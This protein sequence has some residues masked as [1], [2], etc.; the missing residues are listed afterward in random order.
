M[1]LKG[2]A[3]QASDNPGGRWPANLI[4]SHI[5]GPDGCQRVGTRLVK[6]DN[7]EPCLNLHNSGFYNVGE[8]ESEGVPRGAL[9]GDAL[10][11]D[12]KCLDGCPVRDL[13]EQSGCSTS[14]PWQDEIDP[15]LATNGAVYAGRQE[16]RTGFDD[17]SK[18]VGTMT[19]GRWPANLVLSHIGG[20][21]GCR[22]VGTHFEEFDIR[23]YLDPTSGNF[24]FWAEVE[25]TR[26]EVVVRKAGQVVEDWECVKGCPCLDL[27]E[28]SG[29]STSAL[30]QG[31]EGEYL[32]PSREGWR[33]RRATGG[34]ADTGGASRFFKQVTTV[35]DLYEY[36]RAMISPPIPFGVAVVLTAWPEDVETWARTS[37]TGFIIHGFTPTEAQTQVLYDLLTP[38]GY[39]CL[40]AP[41]EQPT[42]HTGAIRLED[43]GFEIRDALLWVRGPGRLH[44]IAKAARKE[45][46]A[47]C[48]KLPAKRGFEAVERKEGSAR[49]QNPRA[50]TGRTVD[51]VRNPHPCLHPEAVVMTDRGCRPIQ[52]I[53]V[54][55]WVLSA[56]GLFHR[57]EAVTRHPYTSEF[58]YRIGVKGTNLTTPASDN[59]PFLIWRPQRK[60]NYI[61]GGQVIWASA[62]QV[63]KG[64]YTMTPVMP[65]GSGMTAW[66]EDLDFWFV[67]GLWLAEGVSQVAG[68]GDNCYPSFSLHRKETYLV[69]RIKA[70]TTR[71]VSVYDQGENGV[72]VMAFDPELGAQF[73]ALGGSGSATKTIHPDVWLLTE[74]QRQALVEGYLAGDGGTVHNYRQAKSVSTDLATQMTFLAESLGYETN[75]FW[76]KADPGKIGDWHFKTTLP[77]YQMQFFSKDRLQTTRKAASPALVMHEGATYS[78]RYVQE[79]EKVPYQGDVVNLSVEGCP[80]FQT[81]VGMSHNTVKPIALMAKLLADVPKDQG[82][83]LDPFLGSGTTL[84]ACKQTGHDA[85]GI[86]R[87][88]EYLKVADARVRYWDQANQGPRQGAS[89]RSDLTQTD[90]VVEEVP[91][92]DW[93]D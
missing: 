1:F 47:G 75:L 28:Q 80:T 26:P 46:E 55:D 44:Y 58:L 45:R 35:Q 63:I 21:E 34:F 61:Q 37:C 41:D 68:H 40:F 4:L 83:V 23:N 65:M 85:I 89:I 22:L 8:T 11:E 38:G 36:L 67:F 54:G 6:G 19:L 17:G 32:D 14:A 66:P 69:D 71:N 18:V 90:E 57:V 82:P 33:F 29:C 87:E 43:A 15:K 7:R 72:Q 30:R 53:K 92:E 86:E 13:D 42:G 39:I 2:A 25:A 76:F 52:T 24:S 70:L 16:G 78:L 10:V 51:K 91:L 50:G 60:G 3:F 31:G 74:P 88:E 49:V 64:D 79:V 27:D 5:G 84:I 59:H 12:W 20:P 62:D 9:H 77:H 73:K 81:A 56:D 48:R 93:F